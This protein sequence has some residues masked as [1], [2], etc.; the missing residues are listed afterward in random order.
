MFARSCVLAAGSSGAH[1]HPIPALIGG[2]LPAGRALHANDVFDVAMLKGE[3]VGV[4]GAA[5]CWRDRYTPP[6]GLGNARLG[7]NPYLDRNAG[8]V[9]RAPGAAPWLDRVMTVMGG[10][11]PRAGRGLGQ[12]DEIR[13]APGGGGGE[14][15]PV[16][17]PAGRGLGAVLCRYPC[18]AD[19]RRRLMRQHGRYPYSAITQRPVWDWP[20]GR[21]LAVHI[22]VNLEVFPFAEGLGVPLA[23][24]LPEP[25]VLN[26]SWRDWGNRVGVWNLLEALDEHRLPAAWSRCPMRG[27]T[28]TC[29]RCTAPNGRPRSGPIRC[30]SSSRRCCGSRRAGRWCSASRCIPI[31]VGWPFRL[32]HLRRV[33]ARLDA[34]RDEVWLCRPGEIAANARAI[35]APRKA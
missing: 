22:S 29:R 19:H 13:G 35:L 12:R 33:L 7:A 18:R 24:P 16:P 10:A 28:T 27:R 26:F 15:P 25:D 30:W 1:G 34:A 31:R 23:N 11:E 2:G 4:L 9:A 17:R 14:A 8:F 6:E 3:R 20:G 5:A 21:R 32:R